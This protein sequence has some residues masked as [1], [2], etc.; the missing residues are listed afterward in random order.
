LSNYPLFS[1]A[2]P[3]ALTE[4][5]QPLK[6]KKHNPKTRFLV[7]IRHGLEIYKGYEKIPGF[8]IP[9][10]MFKATNVFEQK[11]ADQLMM[12]LETVVPNQ[13]NCWIWAGAK[14]GSYPSVYYGGKLQ[15]VVKVLCAWLTD[16][17][18][19]EAFSLGKRC[20]G[21]FCVNPAHYHIGGGYNVPTDPMFKMYDLSGE[22]SYWTH[23]EVLPW[24][25]FPYGMEVYTKEEATKAK[26]SEYVP[27]IEELTFTDAPAAIQA[28]KEKSAFMNFFKIAP[29]EPNSDETS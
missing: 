5:P 1:L 20:N 15:G 3:M 14:S 26:Q 7:D 19:P 11:R 22:L 2:L 8:L 18:A 23:P 6:G 29:S 28:P 24:Q 16:E 21:K 17:L 12:I 4:K 9:S 25:P 27:T 10:R 13:D